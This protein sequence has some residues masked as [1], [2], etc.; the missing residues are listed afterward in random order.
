[1]ANIFLHILGKLI[2]IVEMSVDDYVQQLQVKLGFDYG[3]GDW[4]WLWANSFEGIRQSETNIVNLHLHDLLG[5]EPKDF[6][7]TICNSLVAM[8][9][10]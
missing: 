2:K 10:Q 4:A 6:E 7:T 1:M 8:K 5:W 9:E 3:T